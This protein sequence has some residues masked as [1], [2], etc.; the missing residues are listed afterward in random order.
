MSDG[1]GCQRRA[2][3]DQR[4]GGHGFW[5]RAVSAIISYVFRILHGSGESA[6]AHPVRMCGH[7][8]DVEDTSSENS[9][10]VMSRRNRGCFFF[11]PDNP[12]D[13]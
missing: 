7:T 2:D 10:F 11:L 9:T 13:L 3:R 12:A 5:Q 4:V 6:E 1:A 8:S